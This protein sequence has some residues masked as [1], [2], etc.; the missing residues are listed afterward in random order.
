[1][2]PA[3]PSPRTLRR[4]N[5]AMQA[6]IVAVLLAGLWLP[7][8]S[9][10][11]N[12]LLAFAVT[13]LPAVIQRD[14]R[15]TLSPTATVWL[16]ATV[17]LHA[18]GM[19]GPY[20]TVWWWDHLTHTLSAAVVASVGYVAAR[21]LDVHSDAIYFPREFMVAFVLLFTLALGVLWEVLEFAART[22]GEAYGYGP[23][24]YQYGLADTIVDLVFDA[25]GALVVAAFGA[26]TLSDAVDALVRRLREATDRS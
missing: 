6:A 24:L 3:A 18:V 17:L 9:V 2:W 10:V 7:N 19:L 13:L 20:G 16:T 5:R 11:I 25:V 26:G 1:M 12:A 8:A 14:H 15:L 23:L 22:L 21:A 4:L